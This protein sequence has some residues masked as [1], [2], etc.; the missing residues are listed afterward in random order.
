M[1]GSIRSLVMGMA[2][3]A[4]FA[5]TTVLPQTSGAHE[6]RPGYLELT[7][8]GAKDWN[9][10]WKVPT[11]QGR[12]L[13]LVLA[14][15]GDCELTDPVTRPARMAQIERWRA[16]CPKGLIGQSITI[17][18]MGPS[19]TD[20]LVRIKHL[21]GTSQTARLTADEPGLTVSRSPSQLEVA[22]TYAT[23]GVEHILMGIDH[24]LF[25]LAVLF[26][27]G[28]VRRLVAAITAFTVAHSL[29]LAA[30]TLGWLH[31]PAAPVEAAIALS[32]V[33]V[34]AEIMRGPEGLASRKPWLIAFAFG[35]LHG[36]GFAGALSEV[37]LP[38]HAIPVALAF[39]NI[40]VEVGQLL[41]IAAVL[42]LFKLIST[43]SRFRVE[44]SDASIWSVSRAVSLPVSYS[45]GILGAFWLI[46]R[47]ASFWELR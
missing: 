6:V 11:K 1:P 43:A 7:A 4:L 34:A 20:V 8:I 2:G 44:E 16:T 40:G 24:L 5:L 42:A 28:N 31:V 21:D 30:A 32:I 45:V 12:R 10:L 38:S 13:P 41:F 15:P 39:F 46:E 29:T 14:M 18:G 26:L 37:G 22:W 3:L 23:L 25:V 33:F 47:T 9:V 36:L 19:R 17:D 35:L 27:A